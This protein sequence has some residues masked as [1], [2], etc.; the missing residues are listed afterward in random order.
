M[1]LGMENAAPDIMDRPPHD[2]N[3]GVFTTGT[4]HPES[5]T[6]SQEPDS[7]HPE[8]L[9]D[10]LVYG[11]IA[12]AICLASFVP[13]IFGFG[14]G[15]LGAGGCNDSRPGCEVVFRARATCFA[16]MSWVALLLA[17]QV[18]NMRRSLFYMQLHSRT[19]WTP[20]ARDVWRN[21]VLFWVRFPPLRHIF[22]GAEQCV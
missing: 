17:W 2:A 1:G 15:D 22:D 19:P 8:I 9:V 7:F 4:A 3:R 5:V 20:W 11:I 12:G 14:S 10:M 6:L 21:P 13:V 18:V 16:T